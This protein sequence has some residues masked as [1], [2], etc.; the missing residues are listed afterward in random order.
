MKKFLFAIALLF[1]VVAAFAQPDPV[2]P[3][4]PSAPSNIVAAEYFVDADPGFGNGTVISISAGVNL[5]N[6]NASIN[7][8]GLTIGV[9]RVYIRT[10]N[11][12]GSWS[13][14]SS[15]E[16]LYDFDPGYSAPPAALQNITAAEYF[17]DVD[18]GFGNGANIP[19]SPG[20][21]VSNV[22]TA[23][24][25]TGLSNGTHRLYIRTRDGNGKWSITS[26]SEFISDSN[27]AYPVAPVS[28][29]QL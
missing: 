29:D 19:V 21:N 7:T 12:S 15:G 22:V 13:I 25:T 10:R 4:P 24:N 2:Y 20:T 11:A 9:H 27:P 14:L 18:P 1:S 6:V 28:E 8:T 26:V 17:I 23:I 3:T 16:F 5:I